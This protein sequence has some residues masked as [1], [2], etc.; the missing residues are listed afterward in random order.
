MTN[1]EAISWL[2]GL[3]EH[4]G[5]DVPIYVED[6]EALGMAC[7]ALEERQIGRWMATE[8]EEG[9]IVGYFCSVCDLPMETDE[10]TKYC[11]NCGARMEVEE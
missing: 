1:S 5:E 6:V 7:K 4:C 2:V 10:K 11:P 9:E 8:N 3:I